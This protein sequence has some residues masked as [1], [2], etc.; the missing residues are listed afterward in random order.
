M[1]IQ[2][3]DEALVN[4]ELGNEK[5]RGGLEQLGRG[6]GISEDEL[7]DYLASLKSRP[8]GSR[9]TSLRTKPLQGPS[10]LAE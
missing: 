8:E 6:E 3:R 2:I 10:S 7:N 5:I 1:N 4:R 9:G